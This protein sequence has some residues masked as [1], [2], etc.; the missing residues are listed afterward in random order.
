MLVKDYMHK[1]IVSVR[2]DEPVRTVVRLI[3]NLGIGGVPVLVGKKLV[4]I[5]TEEDILGKLFPSIKD[6]M[7]DYV[8]SRR[9]EDMEDNL[10]G[11][12]DKPVKSIMSKS[13]RSVKQ[14]TPLLKAQSTMFINKFSRL[15]VVNDRR[16][17]IGIISQGDIFRAIAGEEI[18]YEDVDEYHDWLSHH[19]DLIT[20]WS[21]RLKGEIGDLVALFKKEGIQ[22]IVDVG[23]GTGEHAI[24]LARHGFT[25]MG[26]EKSKMMYSKAFKKYQELPQNLQKLLTFVHEDSL[27]ALNARKDQFD[28]AIFMGN[29]LAHHT[30]NWR[31]LLTTTG[32]SLVKTNGLLVAQVLNFEKIFHNNGRLSDFNIVPSR[33]SPSHEYAFIEFYDPPRGRGNTDLTLTMSILSFDGKRWKPSGVNSTEIANITRETI[34]PVLAKEG[35]KKVEFLGSL[36]N[37]SLLKEKFN[38]HV[39]T[40]LTVVARR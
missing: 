23:C 35:L 36:A 6:F 27:E 16:E 25:V 31:Q 29:S 8:H 32:Q 1:T 28:A 34:R 17:L 21:R 11:L 38:P 19:Y 7:E 4:G 30:N 5:V 39:H 3:F 18:P 10:H 9:F 12:L 33:L 40:W 13:V 26:I 20:P 22:R 37:R 24:A 2:E 15:P 14:D